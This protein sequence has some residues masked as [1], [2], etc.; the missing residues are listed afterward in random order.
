MDNKTKLELIAKKYNATMDC[1][2]KL[3]NEYVELAIEQAMYEVFNKLSEAE[4]M[5]LLYSLINESS[6][7]LLNSLINAI[8]DESEDMEEIDDEEEIDE[9]YEENEDEEEMD[10]SIDYLLF[11]L[12]GLK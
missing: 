9:Q 3:L 2:E 12:N 5:L 4:R 1:A 7:T 11:L 6:E 8:D 10:L